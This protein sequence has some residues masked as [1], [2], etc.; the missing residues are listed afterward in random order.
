[1]NETTK[2]RIFTVRTTIGKERQV[3]DKVSTNVKKKGLSVY[4]IV[5]PSEI[6]G[7]FFIEADNTDEVRAAIY[8]V[9]HAKGLVE[10]DI[11]EI[12]LQEL[13]RFFSPI[14]ESITVEEGNIVELTSGPFKGDKA[15]IK[16]VDKIKEE[17]V[18]ELL[19]AAVSIPLTVKLDSIRVIKKNEEE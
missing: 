19:E 10:R 6:R 4:S 16:R 13:D 15:K 17:V 5:S 9:T 12:E 3:I 2:T 8:G 11:Q 14:S 18:V 1:M 7:Y